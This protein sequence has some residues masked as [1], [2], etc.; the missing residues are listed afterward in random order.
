MITTPLLNDFIPITLD[1]MEAIRL[2]N[3]IDSKYMIPASLLPDLLNNLKPDYY[4]Q[5]TVGLRSFIYDTIY[6][7]TSDFEMYKAHQNGKRNRLKIRTR[8]Y[9][10]SALS[11]LEIKSKTNKGITNKIR[12]ETHSP[13]TIKTVQSEAF[14]QKH[15][16]F[17][18][19]MLE[20]KLN[21]SFNRITLVNKQ[22]TERLTIDY[23]LTF[24]AFENNKCINLPGLVIVELKKIRTAQSA[25]EAYM[26][27]KRIKQNGMSKYCLGTALCNTDIKQNAFKA[28]LLALNK[29]TELIYTNK[30][31]FIE[32]AFA[33]ND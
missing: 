11:F 17:Q 31:Q 9:V 7:D 13:A 18:S 32:Y 30:K 3:R 14:I 27:T 10:D 33:Y 28:K 22:K 4:I 25:V 5:E 23:N 6:F 2:M 15:S 26:Q 21:S 16:P 8:Q 24:N 20:A 1:K 29:L 19:T 12:I